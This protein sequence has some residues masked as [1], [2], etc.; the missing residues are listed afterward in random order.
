M[1][2]AEKPIIIDIKTGLGFLTIK[3][4]KTL[5]LLIGS[6]VLVSNE[7]GSEIYT[8]AESNIL[9]PGMALIYSG[10]SSTSKKKVECKFFNT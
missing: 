5:D 3:D 7:Y 1:T 8:L 9:K 4:I 6:E 2:P 10:L